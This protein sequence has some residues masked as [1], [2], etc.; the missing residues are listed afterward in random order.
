MRIHHIAISF[1][2]ITPWLQAE[3]FSPFHARSMAMGQTGV[4]SGNTTEATLLNPALL[5]TQKQSADF[6]MALPIIGITA[7]DDDDVIDS[8]DKFDQS[9]IV[10]R[11]DQATTAFNNT[12]NSINL[13]NMNAVLREMNVEL[14]KLSNKALRLN[15]GLGIVLSI[16]GKAF[17]SALS[18]NTSSAVST[19]FSYRDSNKIN[20]ITLALTDLNT[21]T[22][23][24]TV[25][26]TAAG[27]I[28]K[29]YAPYMEKD[30]S[31][32]PTGKVDLGN[33]DSRVRMVG[34][35]ITDLGLSFARQF[36]IK[37]QK[38]SLG[39]TPKFQRVDTFDYTAVAVRKNTSGNGYESGLKNVKKEAEDADASDSG[40]NM[41][42]GLAYSR[43]KMTYA[44]AI[45][46]LISQE[47]ESLNNNVFLVEPRTTIAMAYRSGGFNAAI[48]ADL[49][50]QA[51]LLPNQGT[52]NL[53]L[54]LEYNAW[55]TV[56]LRAGYRHNLAR[57]D[58]D[59]VTAG[60]GLSP[61][62]VS[63]EL[64]LMA[65]PELDEAGLVLQTGF[66]F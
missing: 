30:N 41:D 42:I 18:I 51:G 53:G 22:V 59:L 32:N 58:N 47:Y 54:G 44:L 25:P 31:G 11:F 50:E 33:F 12:Q 26:T 64:A 46:N 61:F 8:I 62:G 55:D 6:A 17:S 5:A 49:T 36:T 38:I 65:S 39:L 48:D 63:V 7:A 16:P 4:A 43:G 3:N 9:N 24:S 2:L 35:A 57:E 21:D 15:A 10:D 13:Q 23:N 1:L 20:N 40:F 27:L 56:Q 19:A 66:R 45:K 37:N 52:Q 14:G 28:G 34:I 60:I 29:T